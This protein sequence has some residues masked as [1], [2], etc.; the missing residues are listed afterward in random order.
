MGDRVTLQPPTG[1][2]GTV[3]TGGANINIDS[4]NVISCTLQ[5]LTVALDGTSHIP[6][7]IK[8]NNFTTSVDGS[9]ITI[10][11][12]GMTVA[13]YNG[14]GI[15]VGGTS[16]GFG[17]ISNTK[18]A[19]AYQCIGSDGTTQTY[20]PDQVTNLVFNNFTKTFT[21]NTLTLTPE[22]PASLVA[23]DGIQIS[24]QT[25]SSTRQPMCNVAVYNG[26]VETIIPGDQITAIKMP[27]EFGF[28][29][30][31]N[32]GVLQLELPP[33][34]SPTAG[35]GI[36]ISANSEITN[37]KPQSH[38]RVNGFTYLADTFNLIDFQ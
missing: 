23:G 7:T 38:V 13:I 19:P 25:I 3:Y 2:G 27:F 26:I 11:H 17:T 18:P 29:W 21:N 28:D 6:S 20:Q 35:N 5:P 36:S 16:P 22:V 15:G 32:N 31:Q 33:G 34:F 8:F 1:S 12:Q 9:E 10:E 4:S 37:T 24:G 14:Y 30:F